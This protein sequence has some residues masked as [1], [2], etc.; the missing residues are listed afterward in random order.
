MGDQL[1]YYPTIST[2]RNT[3]LPISSSALCGKACLRGFTDA[4]IPYQ[5]Y[6]LD[7]EIDQNLIGG[8][9]EKAAVAALLSHAKNDIAG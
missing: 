2:Q 4:Q 8:K 3:A 9:K 1:P 5:A 6:R 7:T